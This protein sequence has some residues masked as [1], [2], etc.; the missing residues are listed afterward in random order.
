MS[1]IKNIIFDLGGVIY[2]IDYHKTL[3]AFHD[4]GIENPE[5]IYSQARQTDVFDQY[6]KGEISTQEFLKALRN[7]IDQEVALDDIKNAWNALLLGISQHRL[8]FLHEMKKTHSIFLLSNTNELHINHLNTELSAMGHQTLH[9]FF[10]TVYYSYEMGMRKPDEEIF[11][12][13]IDRE[14]LNPKESIFID[15]TEQHI[16][17]AQKTGLNTYHHTQG[18]IVHVLKDVLF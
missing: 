4:L 2:D 3:K 18:D 15:D 16:L 13:V 1:K 11:Q 8:D 17:G 14:N 6:E 7:I 10:N 12:A 9:P 5:D